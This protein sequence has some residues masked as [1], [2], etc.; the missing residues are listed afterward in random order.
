[1]IL[2][3]SSPVETPGS[4]LIISKPEIFCGAG[5]IPELQSNNPIAVVY[6]A[7]DTPSSWP[8]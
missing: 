7:P 4:F 6:D 1:M 2:I 3:Q 8:S 5:D